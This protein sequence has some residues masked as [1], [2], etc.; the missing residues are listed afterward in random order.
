MRNFIVTYTSGNN[1]FKGELHVSAMTIAEAQDKFLNWLITQPTYVH[2][3]QLTFEF[4][5]IQGSL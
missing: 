3:W 5:E 2:M 4:K 1:I